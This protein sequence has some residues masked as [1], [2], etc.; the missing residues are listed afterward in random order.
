MKISVLAQSAVMTFNTISAV[1][2]KVVFS[3]AACV[4]AY[5]A[6]EQPERCPQIVFTATQKSMSGLCDFNKYRFS[7]YHSP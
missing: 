6:Q 1:I 2:D 4:T 3:E 5:F 7:R